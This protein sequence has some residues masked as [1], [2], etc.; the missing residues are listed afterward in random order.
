MKQTV[1]KSVTALLCVVA[2]CVCST[3]AIGKY[4]TAMVDVAKLT[5]AA[6]ASSTGAGSTA[7][8]DDTTP[9][10]DD[11]SAV[12]TDD[13][14]APDASDP[15]AD[16][17]A[18]ADAGTT[19]SGSASTGSASTGSTTG[20]S[21]GSTAADPT[22]YSKAQIVDYY[23]NAIKNTAKAAKL[24][25]TKTEN[26]SIVVDT[27]KPDSDTLKKIINENVLS[28]YAKPSTESKSFTNGVAS[29]KTKAIDYLPK[30][31]LEAAGVKTASIVKS[32][33]NYVV[34]IV[35]IA[36][37]TTLQNPKAKYVSQC[38]APLDLASVDLGPIKIIQADMNYPGVTIK[39]TVSA[40]GT[41]VSSSIDQ[42]LNGTGTANVIGLKPSATVHGAWTQKNTYKY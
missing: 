26:I 21:A 7:G 38:A 34:T 40:N 16:A 18:S 19:D 23:N 25:V 27:M 8:G 20:G 42:P 31:K 30:S 12:P 35:T 14:A 33:S 22:K 32:G 4:T 24:T 5:P 10:A 13:T 28:K 39:A 11:Q 3:L 15:A 41:L 2:V 29:D 37:K 1:I 36:E 6:Q 17:S 9:V